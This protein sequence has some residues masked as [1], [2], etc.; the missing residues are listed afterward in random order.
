MNFLFK[1]LLRDVLQIKDY[2]TANVRF[3]Q[4]YR[5]LLS[6]KKLRQIARKNWRLARYSRQKTY[7]R[8]VPFMSIIVRY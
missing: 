8:I 5:L 7:K 6:L 4:P 3:L 2:G 1:K